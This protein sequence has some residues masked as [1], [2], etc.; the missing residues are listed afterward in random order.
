ML[1]TSD[2]ICDD[3][4]DKNH[5]ETIKKGRKIKTKNGKQKKNKKEIDCKTK[6]EIVNCICISIAII[7]SAYIIAFLCGLSAPDFTKTWPIIAPY[8][9]GDWISFWISVFS[10]VATVIIAISSFSID[11]GFKDEEKQR[12]DRESKNEEQEKTKVISILWASTMS[13][14]SFNIAHITSPNSNESLIYRLF[15]QTPPIL[16]ITFTSQ[17]IIPPNIDVEISSMALSTMKFFNNANAKN[18]NWKSDTN[19]TIIQPFS[20]INRNFSADKIYVF[21][22]IFTKKEKTYFEFYFPLTFSDAECLDDLKGVLINLLTSDRIVNHINIVNINFV[23]N[24]NNTL[25]KLD[26]PMCL[27]VDC[28]IDV[29]DPTFDNPGLPVFNVSNVKTYEVN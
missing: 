13:F 5:C 7:I 22:S 8:D 14:D 21:Y 4:L 10:L 23:V 29:F 2:D 9:S 16:K 28:K 11:K 19:N 20:N 12:K 25:F 27:E 17:T 24:L 18:V 26:K 3:D 6:K 15:Q 1:K